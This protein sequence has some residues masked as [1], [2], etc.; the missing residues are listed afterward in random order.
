MQNFHNENHSNIHIGVYLKI[1]IIVKIKYSYFLI[2]KAGDVLYRLIL[3][4]LASIVGILLV[5]TIG[6]FVLIKLSPIDPVSMKFNLLG[7]TPDPV[8]VAQIREQLGLNDPWWQ[9]YLRWLGQIVQGDF[10]ESILY[11]LPV[12]T[13]LGG[14]LP[15]TLGLVSLAL[16]MGIVVTIPLG[17]LSAKYQDS[18]IDHGV[19][20][21]TFLALAIPGFW[22]GLLL[23]YLFGVKLQLVSITNTNGFSAY[24]LPAVTLALWI[25]GLYIRRLRNA[26]LEVS[27]Q[28]FVQGARAL[29]FPEWM[30]YTRYIF[31]HVGLMLL[32]MMGVTMGAM[33]GG[34]AVIETVFS[35]KGI[36]YMMVQGIMARDYVL[37][38]GY[39]IWITLV[40]IVINIIIDVLSVW[41]NPKR[42]A[43]I[44]GGSYE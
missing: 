15:N 35:I 2:K 31:P 36:G 30:V 21:V 11:A 1:R 23:L 24:V 16:V 26:I 17:M 19:R 5:V 9:Q 20:L 3:Q 10:G 7:A 27:R 34:S 18:W 40:F 37:M 44:K 29:G 22:V 41:L 42:R 13:I 38:Q 28:P 43:A 32:P 12:A 6:T 39:I 4:R 25:C 8:V 14:A 33:L